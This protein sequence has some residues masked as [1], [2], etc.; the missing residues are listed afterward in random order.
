M[1]EINAAGPPHWPHRLGKLPAQPDAATFRLASYVNLNLPSPPAYFWHRDPPSFFDFD[2]SRYG[3]CVFAG[4]A[5]MMS[6]WAHEGGGVQSF[7]TKSVL[8][9]YTAVT[10]F[11][12]H[13]PETDTG[14]DMKAAARYFR[15][16]GIEDANGKR[17]TIDAY[18]SLDLGNMKHLHA[19]M[20]LLGGVGV[21]FKF[22]EY[23]MNQF[24]RHVPW[25]V[26]R[27]W[28][29]TLGLSDEIK[30]GHY[31]PAIGV[32]ENGNLMCVT[33]GR[34]QEMT[35]EFYLRYADEVICYLDL[36]RLDRV[37]ARSPEGFDEEL[38]RRHL[39]LLARGSVYTLKDKDR[40]DV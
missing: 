25:A 4:A 19:A 36:D 2:N 20:W 31:V 17:Q 21:G 38:L 14:A 18:A 1:T 11:N 28:R 32:R 12:P 30:G 8:D 34:I 26:Q 39:T 15:R 27:S 3:D 37:K 13:K 33:W 7:T 40:F 35:P 22:P 10:G 29:Y 24:D 6:L 5:N 16:V 23:A 9:A